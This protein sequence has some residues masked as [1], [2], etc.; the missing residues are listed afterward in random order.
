MLIELQK[1]QKNSQKNNLE[2]VTNEYDKKIPKGRY[3]YQEKKQETI[4]ELTLE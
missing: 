2:T 4:D 3:V 1:F